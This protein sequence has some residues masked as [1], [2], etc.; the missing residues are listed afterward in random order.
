MK[1][2]LILLFSI[3]FL[4]SP[5]VKAET[6]FYCQS[7]FATGFNFS[8]ENGSWGPAEFELLRWTI[9][10]NDSYS[11]L[12]GLDDPLHPYFCSPAYTHTPNLLACL[13][14][15]KNGQSFMF[16]KVNNRFLFNSSDIRGY[17]DNSPDT[18]SIYVGT[19]SKF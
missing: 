3:L 15:Y 19:C 10:F 5:Y 12:Y 8:V 14:G 1:K 18:D 16:N 9:K 6:V 2:I 17:V 4:S 7:E 13:S 11:K